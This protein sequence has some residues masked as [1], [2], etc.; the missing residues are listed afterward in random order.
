M[1][2]TVRACL[3]L[4][5]L[6]SLGGCT[7]KGDAVVLVELTANVTSPI[8]GIRGIR[9]TARADGQDG[10]RPVEFAVPSE[11]DLPEDELSFA[12]V[13]PSYVTGSF[14]I[15]IEA[16]NGSGRT[17]GAGEDSIET[18]PG[19]RTTLVVSLTAG[20]VVTT[21]DMGESAADAAAEFDLT[22]V[23]DAKFDFPATGFDLLMTPV[24]FKS[25]ADLATAS[26]LRSPSSLGGSCGTTPDC[27][28]GLTCITAVTIGGSSVGF[29]GGYCSKTCAVNGDCTSMGATCAQFDSQQICIRICD[30]LCPNDRNDEIADSYACCIKSSAQGCM[31]YGV[32]GTASWAC[33]PP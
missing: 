9:F 8:R 3:L 22:A 15:E 20:N 12:V 21:D 2:A 28:A 13:V 14:E 11:I 29:P 1:R 30:S 27:A 19:K 18:I 24:D 31:P 23:V 17:I 33:N 7:G 5:G 16:R 6:F 10:N 26:D 32:N 4:L 25:A